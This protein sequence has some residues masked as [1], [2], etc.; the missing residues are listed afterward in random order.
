MRKTNGSSNQSFEA[1]PIKPVR[2][3]KFRLM[4]STL[5]SSL[6]LSVTVL[7]VL[8]YF[9]NKRLEGEYLNRASAVAR[10]T[11]SLV[12]GEMIDN[13]LLTLEKDELYEHTLA[14]LRVMNDE[15]NFTYVSV[16]QVSEDGHVFVFDS[17]YD[18]PVGL[19][20]EM[21]WTDIYG[22]NYDREHVESIKR[23]E[24]VKPIIADSIWGLLLTAYEPIYREDGSV[25]G[26]A[27]VDLLMSD[28]L[29]T[30]EYIYILFIAIAV[31]IFA[32]TV[33]VNLYVSRKYVISPISLLV[34]KTGDFS[35]D[36]VKHA[37]PELKSKDELSLLEH[38]IIDLEKRIRTEI[39]KRL[40][41]EKLVSELNHSAIALLSI[42]E[43][44]FIDTMNESAGF[45]GKALNLDRIS[46]WKSCTLPDG[47]FTSQIF[48]WF[49][50]PDD[51]AE[52]FDNI[53]RIIPRWEEIFL[54]GGF[55]N[56]PVSELPEAEILQSLG[57]VSIFLAPIIFDGVLWGAVLYEDRS[58]ERVFSESEADVL[59][60]AA[61]MIVYALTHKEE[62]DKSRKTEERIKLML[63]SSPLCCQIWDKNYNTIDCNEAAV[64]LYGFK[65]KQEYLDRFISS[66]SPPF[67][68]DGRPSG[69]KAMAFV[70]GAF[71]DGYRVFEWLHKMPNNDTTF[72]AEITLV[73]VKYGNDDAVV[74]YTRDLSEYNHMMNEIELR[75]D[76]LR[77]LN[78]M[79][80]VLLS[81]HDFN[82]IKP[83]IVAGL[84]IIGLCVSADSVEIWRNEAV[85]DELHA[86]SMYHWSSDRTNIETAA[87]VAR[88]FSYNDT[89]D[90]A[91][92]FYRGEYV[93]GPVSELSEKDQE[94]L[95][96]FGVLSVLV[97]PL[98]IENRFWGICCIDDYIKTRTFTDE[99]IS[100]LRSGTLMIIGA[101]NRNEAMNRILESA[102]KERM[103]R[104]QKEAAQTASELQTMFLANMSHEIRTPMNAV[105]GMS[106]LLLLEDL[107]DIQR[108]YANSINVSATALL[109]LINDILDITKI[110]SGKMELAPVHY[111]F[112]EMIDNVN[113]I[114]RLLASNKDIGYKF[115]TLGEMPACL[116][117]DDMRLRQVLI[118]ILS[119]AIKFTDYGH[120]TFTIEVTGGNIKF[121]IADT[122]IGIKTEEQETLFN[123]FVQA[124]MQKNRFKTGTGLGL[125][126]T[127]R[128]VEIMDGNI[129]LDSVYGKGSTFY[130]NIPKV[131]GTN[132]NA[133]LAN[134]NGGDN[135]KPIY[136]PTAK[137][138][139][140][141][142]NT[143]NLNVARGFLRLCR[144]T[145]DT[146]ISGRQAIDILAK[147]QYDLVFMDHMMPGMD[148]V[149]A[150]KIIREM[151]IR[152][153]I[154]ALTANAIV[155]MRDVFLQAGMN[156][157]M[158]KPIEKAK[159]FRVL[160]EWLPLE[161]QTTDSAEEEAE[162]SDD[163]NAFWDR[164][165]T[166]D[167]LSS[168]VGLDMVAGQRSN[169]KTSLSL[170]VTEIEKGIKKMRLFLEKGELDSLEV[171]A[172]SMKGALQN[173]GVQKLS[174]QALRLEEASERGDIEY[175]R[176]NLEPFIEGLDV[177][178]E[179][180]EAAFA[181]SGVERERFELSSEVLAKLTGIFGRMKTA[182]S[183]M[184]LEVIDDELE[185]L[186]A[187]M[188][189]DGLKDS[190]TQISEAVMM[191]DYDGAEQIMES[192]LRG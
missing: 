120:V 88:S 114:S 173:I 125:S 150:T 154:I 43:E 81:A 33:F 121:T 166:I 38:S 94:F 144:I 44:N 184:N 24:H 93:Q 131:I 147:D 162:E 56:G 13:Y 112:M 21:S 41:H 149:E 29:R 62:V 28:V 80:S 177:L 8:N 92:K 7:V 34:K 10:I 64:R 23:G 32:I 179:E 77:S 175:C 97:I 67:Q 91:G 49:A 117:G 105:L 155:G 73:K 72:P 76:L 102:E 191:M 65:D 178:R 133:C 47:F 90:W 60:S 143:I 59:H 163:D 86:F 48:R 87:S 187:V 5:L 98:F 54:D 103:L 75:G 192:L 181:V 55:I 104:M 113:S 186:E 168:E 169:Y 164:I 68:P 53:R 111:N 128:L 159:F 18:V 134:G 124:D 15:H 101:I 1:D 46:V 26:Y 35:V 145:P 176:D 108:S 127:R 110:Q 78:D 156:D 190:L 11:A 152:D 4:A 116:Y 172:H 20:E 160:K 50:N 51:S 99:E 146:A 139:V 174:E 84:K 96:D 123:A 135:G 40:G 36:E 27:A 140:V 70:K 58:K 19:G 130:I 122:G 148:G 129:S 22:D 171:A 63:D 151:G 30:Q 183:E 66:C 61:M 138:L 89:D 52:P 6:L 85:G 119:N 158:I 74:G 106:E 141:D 82:D 2:S 79:A 161:K 142:D 16:T 109:N 132:P 165:N 100:I 153:P 107:G 17:D 182:F 95:N 170:M 45:I 118:N 9:N 57:W 180:L 12:T 3:I 25:A 157:V 39:T 189:T 42:N 136:A 69:E 31:F 14:H 185:N 188:P 115:E 71:E 126:I 167:G 137:V 83:S 37:V